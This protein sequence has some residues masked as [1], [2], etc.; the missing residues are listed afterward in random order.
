[1]L[2]YMKT[3]Q[4]EM[5][6]EVER[7]HGYRSIAS[8]S[9]LLEKEK[10][11]YGKI[12]ELRLLYQKKAD[13]A[14]RQVAAARKKIYEEEFGNKQDYRRWVTGQAK[15]WC[16]DSQEAV[17][18]FQE[19]VQ[20]DLLFEKIINMCEIRAW[21]NEFSDALEKLVSQEEERI[22][23][24]QDEIENL[25]ILLQ[26]LSNDTNAFIQESKKKLAEAGVTPILTASQVKQKDWLEQ[27]S[28]LLQQE[29]WNDTER[30]LV[31]QSGIEQTGVMESDLTP[32]ISFLMTTTKR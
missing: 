23:S 19:V 17:Q 3:M 2:E 32:V 6:I 14:A 22:T 26:G 10:S 11:C 24:K 7:D 1:M 30:T 4:P 27:G 16:R 9:Q 5:K 28:T 13:E 20:S 21:H 8:L 12:Q 29:T 15:D 25:Q 31:T 18:D